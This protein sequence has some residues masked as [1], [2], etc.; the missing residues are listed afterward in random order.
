MKNEIISKLKTQYSE[1]FWKGMKARMEMSY[2]K[3][4]DVKDAVN[5][6]HIASLY[7]RIDKYKETGNTEFLMD[8]ANF[9]M[10]EFMFPRHPKANFKSTDSNES[11]GRTTLHGLVHHGPNIQKYAY[12]RDGD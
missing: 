12:G 7:Q 11:P 1:K 10:I 4:G 8:A 2:F 5:D 3:Y 6:D 9:A